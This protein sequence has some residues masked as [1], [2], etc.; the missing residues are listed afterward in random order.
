MVVLLAASRY[1]T[2]K[3]PGGRLSLVPHK[4]RI[5]F[6]EVSWRADMPTPRKDFITGYSARYRLADPIVVKSPPWVH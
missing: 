3:V 1:K 5:R 6:F 2:L 4:L